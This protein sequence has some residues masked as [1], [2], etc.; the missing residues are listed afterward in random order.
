V[1]QG[2]SGHGQTDHWRQHNAFSWYD[3]WRQHNATSSGHGWTDQRQRHDSSSLGWS[4]VWLVTCNSKSACVGKLID[5]GD[6]ILFLGM[7]KGSNTM[8]LLAGAGGLIGGRDATLLLLA[9]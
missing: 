9:G 7:I 5:G 3:Q 6:M 8:L 4:M 1:Q 2:I